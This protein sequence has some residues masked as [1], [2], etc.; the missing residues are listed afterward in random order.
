MHENGFKQLSL[1]Q[2]T[3]SSQ[4]VLTCISAAIKYDPNVNALVIGYTV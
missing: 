4:Y 3:V 2:G 1:S